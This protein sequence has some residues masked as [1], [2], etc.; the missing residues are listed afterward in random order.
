MTNNALI[1]FSGL[2]ATG[3]TTLSR[4]ISEEFKIPLV[5]GDAI[6]ET[7]WNTLGYDFDFEFNDKI[8]RAA[9]ELLFYFA[10]A[11]LSKGKSLVIEGHFSPERNNQ[12]F[13][14]LGKRFNTNLLQVYCDCETETLRKRFK[15][16]MQNDDYHDG[17]RNTIKLYGEDRILNSLGNKNKK[18]EIDGATYALDTT[19]PKKIDY[20]KLFEFI[21]NNL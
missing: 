5:S 4:K 7:I 11:S 15:K 20:E 13:N 12:R 21:K 14:D 2:P 9:F 18:L 3:K 10:E 17:H 8:G 19:N 1:I 6:K 16:R